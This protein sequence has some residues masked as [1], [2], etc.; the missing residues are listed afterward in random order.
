MKKSVPSTFFDDDDDDDNVA[1]HPTTIVKTQPT[2]A[3]KGEPPA[4]VKLPVKA[5]PLQGKNKI[6]RFMPIELISDQP[7]PKNNPQSM[8]IATNNANNNKNNMAELREK[9]DIFFI[10]VKNI[11]ATMAAAAKK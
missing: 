5:D 10:F 11:D 7:A 9:T 8:T 1:V 2:P 6:P 4:S 3:A